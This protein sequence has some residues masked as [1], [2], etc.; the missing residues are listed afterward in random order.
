MWSPCSITLGLAL[1]CAVAM[2]QIVPLP[3]SWL[4]TVSPGTAKLRSE[5]L[6]DGAEVLQSASNEPREFPPASTVSLAPWATRHAL[7][8]LIAVLFV[9]SLVRSNLASAN[10]FYRLAAVAVV[11]GVALSLI[12]L[13]QWISSNPHTVFW[14]FASDGSVFGPFICRNHFAY[15][16]NMSIGLGIGLLLRTRHFQAAAA[17][18]EKVLG[19]L[20]AMLQDPWVMWIGSALIVMVAGL[21]CSLS[22]GGFAAFVGAAAVC[23]AIHWSHAK[24]LG[25]WSSGVIFVLLGLGLTAWLGGATVGRR[26][27][28]IWETNLL[29]GGRSAVW[30]R[31][32]GLF[33]EFPV[34]G[35]GMGTF[36]FVEPLTRGPTDP[37]YMVYDHMENDYLEVLVEGGILQM[38][39][40]L[41]I[42]FLIFRAGLHVFQRHEGT[43][44]GSMAVG[45]LFGLVAVAIHSTVDFGLHVPAVALLAITVVACLSNLDEP[46]VP[47]PEKRT[48]R[49][50][51]WVGAL[52]QVGVLMV[53]AVFVLDHAWH[54]ERAERY[55]LA[56]NATTPEQL[57]KKIAYLEA[58]VAYTPNDPLMHAA[59]ADA[60]RA[61]QQR[62]HEAA[63]VCLNV[64]PLGALNGTPFYADLA[65]GWMATNPNYVIP[66]LT[67]DTI[68]SFEHYF[69]ARNQC[70]CLVQPHVFM[71]IYAEM[72]RKADP[73]E[74]YLRRA[75]MLDPSNSQTWY[76][77]G[78]Q[79]WREN[80]LDRA[81]EC[82]HRS[83]QCDRTYLGDILT[84]AGPVLSADTL[85]ERVIPADAEAV[86]DTFLHLEKMNQLGR[87]Q[88][89]FLIRA[90]DLV[91]MPGANEAD[92]FILRARIQARLLRVD[93]AIDSYQKGLEIHPKQAEWRLEYC[94]FLVSRGKIAEA[95]RE[96]LT[97]RSLGGHNERAKDLYDAVIREIAAKESGDQ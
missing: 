91:E 51:A 88:E 81:W 85:I 29:E 1:L 10:T 64:A 66:T 95:R 90:L 89:R 96:L 84:C 77:A 13:G 34:L 58:A 4:A 26:V 82:W 30:S 78:R 54:S 5:L 15:Y 32:L 63:A 37:H 16:I 62:W 21:C 14:T 92:P 70:P 71:A 68:R 83:L 57:D 65:S 33:P 79:A 24:R 47:A 35:T 97:L 41:G 44:P 76:V 53:L 67:N 36:R 3:S 59:A 2:A 28:T 19:S 48:S 55:R 39:L 72:C 93:A 18:P 31:A 50:F 87:D 22:R 38:A 43:A 80:H 49:S 25:H 61:R 45:A 56:A 7:I 9:F 42:M 86:Y 20:P 75:C 94:E 17:A 27:A 8:R 69:E 40:V 6:P 73:A 46:P 60:Y 11:N 74:R 23:L 52:A 12:G